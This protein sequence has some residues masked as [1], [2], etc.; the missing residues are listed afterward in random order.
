MKIIDILKPKESSLSFE[1]FPPKNKNKEDLLFETIQNL[2]KY[3]PDFASITYSPTGLSK[4]KSIMWCKAL[5]Y[6]F[7]I[8]PMMHITC[9]SSTKEEISKILEQL[10]SDSI[11][12]ILALRGDIL[13]DKLFIK[14][15]VFPHAIDLIQYIKSLNDFCIGCAGYPEGHIECKNISVDIDYLCKKIDAGA[16]F[17][18]TQLFFDNVHFYNFIDLIV[19]KGIT[20]PVICGIMPITS[21]NQIIKF[22][23]ICGATIP[24]ELMKKLDNKSN[25][26]VFNIGIEYTYNQCVDLFKN[27]FKRLHF[28]TLNNSKAVE[29][30]LQRLLANSNI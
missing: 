12:N 11:K 30:I 5:K 24:K 14:D 6:R 25:E 27:G 26:D 15:S 17:I 4:E 28:Y 8:E 19:K 22:T 20:V 13:D 9:I 7:N 21:I 3:K 10:H 18:I 29:Q 2:T 23:N 16:E 1:F